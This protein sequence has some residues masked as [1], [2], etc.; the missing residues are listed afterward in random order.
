[1][2]ISGLKNK[3]LPGNY[4]N[5][6]HA[7]YGTGVILSQA[8]SG[9]SITA[10]RNSCTELGG[11]HFTATP[12]PAANSFSDADRLV[13]HL[14]AKLRW[15]F[16]DTGCGNFSNGDQSDRN[17]SHRAEAGHVY[18]TSGSKTVTLYEKVNGTETSVATKAITINAANTVFATTNTILFTNAANFAALNA[19]EQAAIPT[20]ATVNYAITSWATVIAAVAAGKRVMCAYG[21]TFTRAAADAV[22]VTASGWQLSVWGDSAK[23]KPIVNMAGNG[24]GAG[25]EG[26]TVGSS[27]IEPDDFTVA[28]IKFVGTTA[29]D[30]YVGVSLPYLTTNGTITDLETSSVNTS[31]MADATGIRGQTGHTTDRV[32]F[33]I[34]DC[35][36]DHGGGF[37]NGGGSSRYGGGSMQTYI[38]GDYMSLIGN[39]IRNSSSASHLCRID[40]GRHAAVRNNLFEHGSSSNRLAIKCEA[41]IFRGSYLD[42]SARFNHANNFDLYNVS[43]QW[44][45]GMFTEFVSIGENIFNTTTTTQNYAIS[46]GPAN[47]GAYAEVRGV[48][49]SDNYFHGANNYEPI[50]L[51]SSCSVVMNN[52][53][54]ATN[55][56][57]DSQI[58]SVGPSTWVDYTSNNFVY[59]NTLYKKNS[60]GHVSSYVC[61]EDSGSEFAGIVG[62][63]QNLIYSLP[64]DGS[65]QPVSHEITGTV[66]HDYELIGNSLD[67]GSYP[68]TGSNPPSDSMAQFTLVT[69]GKAYAGADIGDY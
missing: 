14:F 8:L 45:T 68:F 55:W 59:K 33:V 24:T 11:I 30:Y 52:V 66:S 17:V 40:W 28:G 58:V 23:G 9:W 5:A 19:T 4:Y 57:S 47:T 29:I 15:D 10:S 48:L 32:G 37:T 60:V 35:L 63:Y 34:N 13:L 12:T 49:I 38:A 54:N 50:L 31:V 53:L 22:S 26:V 27:G 39:T 69:G 20:G 46:T 1:M 44:F 56:T 16:G 18:K 51:E 42:G 2:A 36:F 41:P 25:W 65:S 64:K 21:S 43:T 6:H 7:P 67:P 3:Q 61:I 62:L